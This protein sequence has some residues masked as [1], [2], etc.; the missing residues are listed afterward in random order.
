MTSYRDEHYAYCDKHSP[1]GYTAGRLIPD[2]IDG[3]K[4]RRRS[5]SVGEARHEWE[6]SIAE[7][8]VTR[9]SIRF[10]NL[11]G[12]GR[13]SNDHFGTIWVISVLSLNGPRWSNLVCRPFTPLRCASHTF[14]PGPTS[15]QGQARRSRG[16]GP[17]ATY[18][19]T[20]ELAAS[21]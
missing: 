3:L 14:A 13:R 7:M 4:L 12:V 21:S 5:N 2:R 18:P 19:G 8:G 20:Q 10:G 1:R 9:W 11:S 6:H 15:Q 16:W 17:Q